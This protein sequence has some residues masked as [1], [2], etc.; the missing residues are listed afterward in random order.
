MSFANHEQFEALLSK[1]TEL[2]VGEVNDELQEKVTLYALYSHI[3]KTM[4]NLAAHW[5][6]EFPDAKDE[7][8]SLMLEIKQLNEKHR[9]KKD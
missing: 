3:A 1:Y 9:Q 7:L 8:K 2:L 4:P 6:K 5:N